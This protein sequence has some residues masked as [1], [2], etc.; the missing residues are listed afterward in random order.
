MQGKKV[1]VIII[2]NEE[3]EIYQRETA[4]GE[5]MVEIKHDKP[6][7]IDFR[8]AEEKEDTDG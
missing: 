2:L 6:L 8:I 7:Q 4:T 3:D 5:Y 1:D